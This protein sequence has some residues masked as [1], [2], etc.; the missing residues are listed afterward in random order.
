MPATSDVSPDMTASVATRFAD[1]NESSQRPLASWSRTAR[2]KGSTLKTGTRSSRGSGV[3][4]LRGVA[5]HLKNTSQR[6]TRLFLPMISFG[7]P[8]KALVAS[9]LHTHNSR[10]FLNTAKEH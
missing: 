7:S 6:V 9:K 10:I 8:Q 1:L 5:R 3:R 4:K 2:Q